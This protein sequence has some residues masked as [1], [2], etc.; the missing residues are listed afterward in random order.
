MDYV[1]ENGYWDLGFFQDMMSGSGYDYIDYY[2]VIKSR[3]VNASSLY[4]TG[5]GTHYN[6]KGNRLLAETIF[7]YI[8]EKGLLEK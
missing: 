6:P 4:L 8:K 2:N 5:E 7:N 1:K 3:E